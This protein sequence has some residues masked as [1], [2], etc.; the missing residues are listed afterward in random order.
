LKPGQRLLLFTDG[1]TDTTNE[2]D[3]FF[4]ATRLEAM[5]RDSNTDSAQTLCDTILAEIKTHQ[6]KQKQYDDITL[7]AIQ[8]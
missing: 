1:A 3:E 7:V 8:S 4:G 5:L 6:G 2:K